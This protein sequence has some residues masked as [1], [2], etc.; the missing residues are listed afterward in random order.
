MGFADLLNFHTVVT[1]SEYLAEIRKSIAHGDATEHTHRPAL[2]ALLESMSKGLTA[3]NEPKRIACGAP[4]FI[5]TRKTVPL[6]H[7]E[8]KDVGTPLEE[9]EKGKGPN[10]EQFKRYID[11][12]PNWILTDYLEYRWYVAGERRLIARLATFDGKKKIQSLPTGEDE[13]THLLE[14]FFKQPALTVE[15]AKDLADRMAGMTRVVRDLIAATFRHGSTK[16]QQQLRNWLSAFKE[17]LIPDLNEAQFS[18]MFAQTLAYGLFAARVHILDSGLPFSREMAAYNLPKTN[19]FLRKLFAQIAGVDMPDTFGWAVDDLVVLLNHANWAKVLKDFGKGKAKHDPVVHFYETF[20][21]A[22]D[23]QMREIRG[24][25]YTPEPVV[26][27]IVRSID[28]LLQK[29]FDKPNGLADEKTLILDPAVG[30]ATFLF[31]VVQQIYARFAQQKGAWDGYVSD[32]LLNRLFGFEL[33]MAPYA[34]AHLKLGM[35]LQDTGYTFS[36]EQRLGIYLTN[37]LEEA[38]RKSEQ[39]FAQF[40]SDEANAAS[41]I[42]RDRPILVVLGNPPYSGHSANKSRDAKGNLTFIGALIEDYKKGCPELHKPA[43]AKWLQNDY[44]KFIRFAQWRIDRTKEGIIG[45]ITD[46]GYLENPTFRGMR[47][48]LLEGFNEIYIYDLHGGLKKK[49][50]APDGGKDVNVFDIQQGVAIMLCVKTQGRKDTAATVHHADLWG[51]REHKYDVLLNADVA[52]TSWT[53]ISPT[54]PQN[55]FVPANNLYTPEKSH[56]L[57]E[58]EKGWRLPDIFNLNGDPAPGI[59]TTHDEFAIAFTEKEIERNVQSLVDTATEDDARNLFKLCKT[60]QWSYE[61]AKE[62]LASGAWKRSVAHILYRPF[63]RRWTVFNRY[64]A[65]HRR[66]R[67]MKHMLAGPNLGIVATRH[68]ETGH[69]AH[70]FCA[71]SIIGHHAVSLK[72]V[73]YL[74]PLYLYPDEDADQQALDHQWEK[75]ANLSADFV[76]KLPEG[77]TPEHVFHYIY[78]VTHSP[79][80]RVR[81]AEFLKRDFARIPIATKTQLFS[82]LVDRGRQLVELH[83][84]KSAA[85]NELITS[86]PE[87]GSNEVTNVSYSEEQ[88]KVWIN[89]AQFFSG[90]PKPVWEFVIGDYVVCE[91]WLTDRKG[92][93]L[94]YD[95]VQHWQ[96]IVVAIKETMRLTAEI[97][98]LIPSWPLP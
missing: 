21:S 25:Y 97:D 79:A 94:S 37:T 46:R 61:K 23:P 84:L 77:S 41:E 68:I 86:F 73:N 65:V 89:H 10:G 38:A 39:L 11:G 30:T 60:N 1:T 45:F 54:E 13:V 71:D 48:S 59:V 58:Y 15:S 24:V 76:S 20:L 33:L 95:D 57:S 91:R 63:D 29:H 88:A 93:E 42:K 28:L 18:D 43:Q 85:L 92:R 69:M 36:S 34:V 3:T 66:E 62:E 14:A 70:V 7:V 90:V 49:E 98:A 81:Y 51:L 32:H 96:R 78:A 83:L 74:L 9:I 8:T 52:S 72:E 35:E 2:K 64:V 50:A 44:V 40:I 6:G 5:I 19:P 17:V 22:Y 55:L 26:S 4:D 53:Q 75:R 31:F 56:L 67:V 47:R 80:Y 12:L 27:Y 87:K 82:K 16:D